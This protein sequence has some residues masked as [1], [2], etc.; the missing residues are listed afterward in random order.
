MRPSSSALW[1][2]RFRTCRMFILTEYSTVMNKVI[3]KLVDLPKQF[4]I[5]HHTK[6]I[7]IRPVFLWSPLTF[8]VFVLYLNSIHKKI[9]KNLSLSSKITFSCTWLNN[10]ITN[11]EFIIL[12]PLNATLPYLLY[13]QT[14]WIQYWYAQGDQKTG[15]FTEVVR[16][17]SLWRLNQQ[18]AGLLVLISYLC[19]ICLQFD[20]IICLKLFWVWG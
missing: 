17:T 10:S 20:S 19:L 2:P 1:T 9:D 16:T 3:G 13:V 12:N 15:R 6:Q 8:C 18:T 11:S 5:L 7:V 4:G 14:D